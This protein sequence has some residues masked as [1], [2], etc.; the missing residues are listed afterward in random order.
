MPVLTSQQRLLITTL[1]DCDLRLSKTAQVL[2]WHRNTLSNRMDTILRQTGLD[3]RR[4]RDLCQLYR[5]MEE[6]S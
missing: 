2:G 5:L 4:F 3:P 1:A 6:Q